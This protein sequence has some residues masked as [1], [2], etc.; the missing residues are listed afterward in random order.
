MRAMIGHAGASTSR[1]AYAAGCRRLPAARGSRRATRYKHAPRARFCARAARAVHGRATRPGRRSPTVRA[2]ARP[3]DPDAPRRR[4]GRESTTRKRRPAM[5]P[6]AR[7]RP[8]R[9]DRPVVRRDPRRSPRPERHR[10]RSRAQRLPASSHCPASNMKL[11]SGIAPVTASAWRAGINVVARHRRRRVE[12]P[13]RPVR[14]D[15]PRGAA[16]ESRHGRRRRAAGG[17]GRAHGDARRRARARHR[18]RGSARSRAGKEADAIAVDLER[19][20]RDARATIRSRTWSRRAAA[21][22]VT[23]VWI[24]RRAPRRD[25]AHAALSTPPTM[26]CARRARGSNGIA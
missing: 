25:H 24:A 11:A 7:L 8:A 19:R 5:T 1:R 3:A 14:R 16:R 26:R 21:S 13:P 6:L 10:A 4:R 9:R 20:R 2:P 17:D 22:D 12:Q 23:D 15:A 18:R